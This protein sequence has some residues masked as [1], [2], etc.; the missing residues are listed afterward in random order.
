M[1]NSLFYFFKTSSLIV[2]VSFI[3]SCQEDYS[4][5]GTDIINDQIINI[6]NQTYPVK[7]Y[8]KKI[9]PF[10]SN[11]LPG[12]LIGHYNDPNFGSTTTHFWVN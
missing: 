12:Y 7:T 8:N 11:G 4:E 10:Q 3:F 2:I 5:I 1:K 6:Q 9:M